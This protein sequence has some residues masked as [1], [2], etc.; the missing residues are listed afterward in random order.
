M[1]GANPGTASAK[2]S[3]KPAA[4]P[5][6]HKAGCAL[7]V[8]VSVSYPTRW[9]QSVKLI[10]DGAALGKWQPSCGVPLRCRHVGEQLVWSASLALPIT[11]ELTYKYVVVN[12]SGAVE[13]AETRPRTVRLL[14]G[15]SHGAAV[16]LTDEWQVQDVTHVILSAAADPADA[17]LPCCS[18][19]QGGAASFCLCIHRTRRIR[20]MCWRLVHSRESSS[21]G[22]LTLGQMRSS[23]SRWCR[24]KGRPC[25]GCASG[26]SCQFHSRMHVP[27]RL[28]STGTCHAIKIRSRDRRVRVFR[29][30]GLAEGDSIHVLGSLSLGN[31]KAQQAPRMTRLALPHWQLE[32]ST[33]SQQQ[34]RLVLT[35]TGVFTCSTVRIAL[36]CYAGAGGPR[37]LS[38]QLSV[39]RGLT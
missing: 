7:T 1:G 19:L 3:G 25:C 37:R 29:D 39:H 8:R 14:D 16:V 27:L 2:P 21:Q 33:L 24:Q 15:L 4:A 20:A 36:F 6:V 22:A 26:W 18:V 30:W 10:G 23:P 9:G 35:A 11:A 28:H 12:E 17:L 5:P 13:D 31:W 32:V 34:H 38:C